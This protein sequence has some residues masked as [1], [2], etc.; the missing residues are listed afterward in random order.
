MPLAARSGSFSGG[1]VSART[2]AR[3]ACD[4]VHPR[5]RDQVASLLRSASSRYTCSG[6]LMTARLRYHEAN[7]NSVMSRDLRIFPV[8]A[9]GRAS[10][11]VSRLGYLNAASR[12]RQ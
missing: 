5:L 11:T 3:I 8:A 2:A 4:F 1:R 12:S 10:S 7:Y 6:R 9:R